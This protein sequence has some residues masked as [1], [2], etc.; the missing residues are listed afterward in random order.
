M[1]KRQELLALPAI[2]RCAWIAGI[3]GNEISPK[4]QD[5]RGFASDILMSSYA[6][7]VVIVVVIFF[8]CELESRER[9]GEQGSLFGRSFC[10]AL[11]RPLFSHTEY[12]CF[13]SITGTFWPCEHE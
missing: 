9:D 10:V 6:Y 2:C 4:D 7:R 13:V 3:T 11:L 8:R 1:Y 5:L 12:Y